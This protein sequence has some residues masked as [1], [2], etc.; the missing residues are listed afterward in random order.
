MFLTETLR[1]SAQ[2]LRANP[3]RSLLTGL[4]MVIG[5]AS[6]ILVVTISLTSRDYILEQVEG[7]GS[8]IIFAYFVTAGPTTPAADADYVKMADVEA[9]RTEL[10]SDVVAA[11]GVMSNAGQVLIEGRPQDVKINGSDQ[12]YQSVRN[13]VISSGRFLDPG[14]VTRRE[15]VALLTDHL[16]ERLYGSRAGA[17]NQVLR[18]YGLQFT[19]IGTFH[20]KVETFGQSEVDRDTIVIPITVQRYFTS[21]ERIDPLYVQ[22]RSPR[23]VERVA[24]RVQEILEARHRPGARYRVDTL[25]AILNAAKNIS[26]ILSLVLVLVSAITLLI[27]GIGI[28]NIML[29]TVTERTREIGVR[30]AVGASARKIL[31]QFLA[32]AMMVSLIGGLIGILVGVAIPLSVG[33]FADI[34]IPI[35]WV[36]IVV[37]FGVSCLVGL[38]FGILPA[39]RAAHLNPT[40]A[41]RYE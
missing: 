19:V 27:S 7:I 4:G 18:L 10:R 36:A 5:T 24:L 38:V 15:K 16:A 20:E 11:T 12:D 9:I 2:A 13:I 28:M 6:V 40:E 3:V 37:A 25:T 17:L 8:N 26:L 33:L 32:E 14:D 39:N 23:D 21:L 1:F 29:V 41:L 22:V 34:R 30:L 35:S 31:L